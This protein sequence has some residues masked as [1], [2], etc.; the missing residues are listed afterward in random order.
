MSTGYYHY[1]SYIYIIYTHHKTSV[2]GVEMNKIETATVCSRCVLC[3]CV[4]NHIYYYTI[5]YKTLDDGG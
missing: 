2:R 5:L 3:V 4:L 1:V